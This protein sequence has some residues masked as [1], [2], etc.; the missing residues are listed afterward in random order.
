MKSDLKMLA[1]SPLLCLKALASITSKA[2]TS[3]TNKRSA[4][5]QFGFKRQKVRRALTLSLTSHAPSNSNQFIYHSGFGF[6][7]RRGAKPASFCLTGE[8]ESG[9][10][11]HPTSQS[12]FGS[13]V[14][15]C[16]SPRDRHERVEGSIKRGRHRPHSLGPD[17]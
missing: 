16:L 7:R 17:K 3:S 2:P 4:T 1:R 8:T 14:R 9:A 6:Q 11:A 12:T 13:A 15:P 5:L 10:H